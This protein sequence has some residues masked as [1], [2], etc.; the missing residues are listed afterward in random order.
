ME[1]LGFLAWNQVF[2]HIIAN[3]VSVIKANLV[4]YGLD[5]TFLG[6]LRIKYFVKSMKMSRPWSVIDRPIMSIKTLH[7]IISAVLS[8][9][10]NCMHHCF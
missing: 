5:H 7:P 2:V 4:L 10:V 9:L 3:Y 6:H 1:F 8:L